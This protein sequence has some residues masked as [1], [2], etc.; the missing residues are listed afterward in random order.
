MKLLMRYTPL[1]L[2]V[3]LLPSCGLTNWRSGE[4]ES[5]NR[6]ALY[7]PPTLTLIRGRV[8]QFVEGD[9]TGSGQRFHSQYSYV[10]ALVIGG[11]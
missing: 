7:D 11:K 4:A 9:L 1:V 8:Y 10:R 2:M 3:L 5:L 6:S